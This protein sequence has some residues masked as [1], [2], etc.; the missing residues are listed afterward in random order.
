MAKLNGQFAFF[1]EFLKHPL[2]IGSVIPSSR[3]LEKR[4]LETSGVASAGTIVELGSGTGGT[5]RA[6][7]SEMPRH[8]RLLSI[9][10]NPQLHA[11]VQ[12]I[13]DDRLIAHLGNACELKRILDRYGLDR[14]EVVISGIPFSTMSHRS[15]VQVVEAISS[16]L[17][18]NGRFVAYQVTTRVAELCRPLLGAGQMEIELLN[19]PPVRVYQWE[20]NG[21]HRRP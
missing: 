9:E 5:T 4:I 19:I 10:I 2:Q 11:K 16:L 3:F 8:A 15:G 6:I 7:L 20:K 13:S 21:G 18:P 12:K 17:A 14:P 1:H